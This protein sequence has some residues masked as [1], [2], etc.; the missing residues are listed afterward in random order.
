M[1]RWNEAR[2]DAAYTD[3]IEFAKMFAKVDPYT[4]SKILGSEAAGN[5]S[6]KRSQEL[7]DN[8][9]KYAKEAGFS[10]YNKSVEYSNDAILDG[11]ASATDKF[12]AD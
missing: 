1:Q 8:L 10:D 3:I 7:L 6:I 2:P 11:K 5:N 4:A 12:N 9:D